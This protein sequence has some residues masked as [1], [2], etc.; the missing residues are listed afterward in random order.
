MRQSVPLP[1]AGLD[2]T[3]AIHQFIRVHGRRPTPAELAACLQTAPTD[4]PRGPAGFAVDVL[5]SVRRQLA[6][7]VAGA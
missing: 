7:I 1:L 4:R 5:G 3:C 6:R 2:E